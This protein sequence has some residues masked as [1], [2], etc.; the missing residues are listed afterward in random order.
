MSIPGGGCGALHGAV[1]SFQPG[2]GGDF[3]THGSGEAFAGLCAYFH[4]E[5]SGAALLLATLHWALC[6]PEQMGGGVCGAYEGPIL[7][8]IL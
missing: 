4:A 2:A 3:C 5:A 1:R 8:P 6:C 7:G